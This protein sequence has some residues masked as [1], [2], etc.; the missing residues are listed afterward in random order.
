M[1]ASHGVSRLR[2]AYEAPLWLLLG[3]TGLILLLTVS[4]LATLMLARAH[5]RRRELAML[6]ALGASRRRLI[7]QIVIEALVLSAAGVALALPLALSAGRM[8]VMMPQ[9][10]SRSAA[11]RT[12]HRLAGRRV[13]AG[14]VA[15]TALVFG[16]LP[17]F[18]ASRFDPLAVLRSG[19]RTQTVDRRRA[20]LQRGLVV[21][22]LAICFVLVVSAMLF[23]PQPAQHHRD[24]HRLQSRGAADRGLWRPQPQ[25]PVRSPNATRFSRC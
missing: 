16:L 20:T 5:A 11:C 19:G 2:A 22:Q 21:G 14:V 7:T 3:T 23:V 17:A 9:H 15:V 6:V 8:L 25:S 10:G 18:Q 13:A 24:R 4:N 1:S 12:G